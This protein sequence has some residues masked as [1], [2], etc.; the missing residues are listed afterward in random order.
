MGFPPA[1][2]PHPALSRN[3]RSSPENQFTLWW[4]SPD[5]C[6]P[7]I[8]KTGESMNHRRSNPTAT[9]FQL[10]GVLSY[11][12]TVNSHIQLP[13]IKHTAAEKLNAAYGMCEQPRQEIYLGALENTETIRFRSKELTLIDKMPVLTIGKG[14][15][16]DE[17]NWAAVT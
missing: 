13:V 12:S 8:P 16:A 9:D 1:N 10:Y 6:S 3:P 4:P 5:D 14:A 17:L 15:K 2:A 7:I 11:F